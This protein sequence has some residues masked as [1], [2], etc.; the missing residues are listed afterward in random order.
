MAILNCDLIRLRELPEI[1]TK[2]EQNLMSPSYLGT[3]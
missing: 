3:L 1:A 2:S